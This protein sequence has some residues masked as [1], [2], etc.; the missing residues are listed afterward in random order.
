MALLG[1]LGADLVYHDPHVEALP[2]NDVRG[3]SFDEAL[4]GCDLALIVTA[5][6][7]VDHEAIADRAPLVVDL[8]GVT[9]GTR[10][11]QTVLL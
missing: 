5:H 10:A 1:G 11:G 6:P 8:R 9:R 7:S 2:D 4:D 3:L